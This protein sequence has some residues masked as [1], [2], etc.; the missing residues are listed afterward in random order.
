MTNYQLKA[1]EMMQTEVATILGD[2]TIQ[3][4]AAL[5]RYEGVRSLVV[6]PRE[7]KTTYG[8]LTFSDIVKKV[9]AERLDP[10]RVRVDDIAVVDARTIQPETDAQMV[11]RFFLEQD[12]SHA[13]VVDNLGQLVGI[14]SMTDLITEV[15]TEPD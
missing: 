7:G 13:P 9:L 3:E 2:A 11:A 8:I 14:V 6:I 5:M 12:C 4:A 15:I 1:M 10:R